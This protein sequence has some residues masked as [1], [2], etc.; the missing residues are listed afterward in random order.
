M[1]AK[2]GNFIAIRHY[3]HTSVIKKYALLVADPENP[4][5]G[6]GWGGGGDTTICGGGY[7]RPLME[8]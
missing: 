5:V 2:F 4:L 8:R 6:V 1:M 3:T 7:N